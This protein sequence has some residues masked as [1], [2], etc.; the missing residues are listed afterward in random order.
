MENYNSESQLTPEQSL[1]VIT[2]SIEE[3]RKAVVRGAGAPMLLWGSLVFVF[4][5][6]IFFLWRASGNPAWNFLWF[7]MTLLG[8][9]LDR[10]LLHPKQPGVKSFIGETLGTIWGAFGILA[11]S[12]ST[13]VVAAAY[14][15]VRILPADIL[16]ASGVT[17]PITTCIV[18]MIGLASAVTGLVIKN[19]WISAAGFLV[20]ILGT[21]F[22]IVL[23]GVHQ[24]L[25]LTGVAL[26]GLVLPGL[27]IQA[28]SR[29][30]AGRV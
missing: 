24:T 7:A 28:E 23:P 1:A 26:V 22:A 9:V 16:P 21:A 5:L 15:L 3:S 4:S 18:G 11:V 29:R 13:L 27:A 8:F 14:G 6:L 19:A 10:C 12:S 25:I 30:E 17:V 2:R 20:G